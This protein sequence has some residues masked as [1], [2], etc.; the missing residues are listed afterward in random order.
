MSIMRYAAIATSNSRCSILSTREFDII[1]NPKY[2][3]DPQLRQCCPN[4]LEFEDENTPDVPACFEPE[5]FF[6]WNYTYV[7]ATDAKKYTIPGIGQEILYVVIAALFYQILLILFESG[8]MQSV[9][10]AIGSIFESGTSQALAAIE[11]AEGFQ[12]DSDVAKETERVHKM[13]KSDD[14]LVVCDLSKNFGSFAAVREI[15]FGVHY[16]ECFGLLGVNGA[17]ILSNL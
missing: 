15:N 6:T 10:A 11:K 14:A 9:R 7:S 3:V 8:V 16:G 17:G 12:V 2:Q 4:C 1:C 5:K 13:T